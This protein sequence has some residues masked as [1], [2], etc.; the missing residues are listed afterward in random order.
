MAT[1]PLNQ[2]DFSHG[3]V[4]KMALIDDLLQRPLQPGIPI[5]KWIFLQS[6]DDNAFTIAGAGE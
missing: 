2:S 6:P 5:R 4:L 3:I 1:V